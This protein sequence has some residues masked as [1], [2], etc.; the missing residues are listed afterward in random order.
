[1][2]DQTQVRVR[3]SDA[4]IGPPRGPSRRL[5]EL[6]LYP[7]FQVLLLI[8][9]VRRWRRAR[10]WNR[11]RLLAGFVGL[12]LL[13]S[14]GTRLVVPGVLLILLAW[15]L[16]PVPDPD[17]LRQIAAQLGAPH[18]LQGGAYAAGTLGLWPGVLRPGVPLLRF[19]SDREVLVVRAGRPEQ[20]LARYAVADLD[21]ITVDGETYQPRYVSFAKEPPR[22]D[23]NADRHAVRRLRL[24]F[25]PASLELDYRGVFAAHLAEIAAHTLHDLRRLA[26][27]AARGSESLPVIG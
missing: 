10:W 20:V 26:Q 24:R 2:T 19:V 11:V 13:A 4:P 14:G 8:P 18:T 1:M 3:S 23:E 25:G 27:A 9:A 5:L 16:A 6:L 7:V 22:L 12:A 21:T 17:R 15:W